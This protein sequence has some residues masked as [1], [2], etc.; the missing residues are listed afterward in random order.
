MKTTAPCPACGGYNLHVA[1]WYEPDGDSTYY[2]VCDDCGYQDPDRFEEE[3]VAVDHWNR[4]VVKGY[5]DGDDPTDTAYDR[6]EEDDFATFGEEDGVGEIC[7]TGRGMHV[8]DR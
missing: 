7:W 3:Y 5:I 6:L 2:M 8:I 1:E 4:R